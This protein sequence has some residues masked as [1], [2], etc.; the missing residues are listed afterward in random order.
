M[1]PKKLTFLLL[2]L[3]Y[4]ITLHSMQE[5][6]R[7]YV[8]V[9]T[10]SDKQ[11]G[12][13]K[14]GNWGSRPYEYAWVANMVS[15]EGKRVI[16]LG[17]GLP[18]Q[19]N[20]FKYVVDKLKPSFYSGIDY[21]GR[22]KSELISTN[23]HEIRYMNMADIDYP[24]QSFDIAYCISTFEH[25]PYETFMKSIQEAH[26]ILKDNGTLIITLDEEWDKDQPSNY[27]NG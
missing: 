10:R 23:N 24:D 22:I 7:K 16:D 4:A 2:N 11:I 5:Q 3:S 9:F 20:W 18:S 8:G 15:I 21:D 19:Y 27:S 26:R 17:V 25:I 6:N 14:Y 12:N 13:I 1:T